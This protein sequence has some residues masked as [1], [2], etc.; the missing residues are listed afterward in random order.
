MSELRKRVT[1]VLIRYFPKLRTLDEHNKDMI[2]RTFNSLFMRLV[3]TGISF[4]FNVLL[5]RLLGAEGA[6]VYALAYTITRIS[7]LIGRIGLDNAVLRFTAANASQKDWNKVAGVYRHAM[8]VMT[9]L[10]SAVAFVVFLAAPLFAR[11]FNEPT[12]IEPMHWMAISILPWSWSFMQGQ[13]LQGLQ[14]IEDSIFVQTLGSSIIAIP[15]LLLLGSKFGVVGAAMSF[16]L[17]NAI[18]ALL[19][20][21]LWKR[22][23]PQIA[24][25]KGEFDRDLLMRTSYPLFWTDFTMVFIGLADTLLLGFFADK[26][27][28][29]IYDQAKRVSVLGSAFLA[30]TSFVAVPK[31]AALFAD[32]QIEKMGRLARNTARLATLLSLPYLVLFVIFPGWVMSIFGPEFAQGGTVLAILSISRLI[33]SVTGDVGYLLIMSGNEKVM[34][35]VTLWTNLLKIGF[36]FVLIPPFGYVGAAVGTMLG[37]SARNIILFLEVYSRLRII[38]LPLPGNMIERLRKILPTPMPAP[39][40]PV[41]DPVAA[42]ATAVPGESV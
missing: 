32:G 36:Y 38:T 40:S 17:G 35:N 37:D 41:L 3:R 19:G 13:L 9:A 7:S 23:T 31:Y 24:D 22:Y 16:V 21:R 4:V 2:Y 27:A 8:V 33:D 42:T 6:G 10:S 34:R 26:S 5:A 29:G 20:L 30:A 11:L 39:V 18:V 12:L 28:V 1:K 15:F 14:K 25:M